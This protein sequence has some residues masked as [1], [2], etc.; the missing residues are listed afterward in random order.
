MLALGLALASAL[1]PSK[2]A[3]AL[4]LRGGG[5]SARDAQKVVAGLMG[6]SSSIGYVYTAEMCELYEFTDPV[7][8]QTRLLSKM[9]FGNNIAAAVLL[10][11]PEYFIVVLAGVAYSVADQV[12]DVLEAPRYP[13]VAW[14][15]LP[16]VFEWAMAQDR[17]PKWALGAFLMAHGVA[18]IMAWE[19]VYDRVFQAKAKLTKQ[20]LS[21]GKF[22]SGNILAT[23]TYLVS[24]AI[25]NA[26]AM[27]FGYWAAVMTAVFT[28]FVLVD[29]VFNPV[30]G[31]VWIALYAAAA[32][33][34]LTA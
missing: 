1:S 13:V 25:G 9:A 4:R 21:V 18:N 5:I 6:L 17:L 10:L 3:P 30:G 29:R 11:K 24:Q 16:L 20:S 34:A 31:Y 32:G 2:V 23:G 26:P 12:G 8:P 22:F 33:I 19:F 7:T 14:A 27:S 15:V 28:K